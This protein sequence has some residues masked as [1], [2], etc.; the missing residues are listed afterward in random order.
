M[1]RFTQ[2][3]SAARRPVVASATTGLCIALAATGVA[4]AQPAGPS[5]AQRS[6][7]Y[8]TAAS[9]TPTYSA[10]ARR[11]ELRRHNPDG[12]SYVHRKHA[13]VYFHGVATDPDNRSR[14]LKVALWHNGH[15]VAL[16]KTHPTK[17]HRHHF[18]IRTHLYYGKNSFRLLV[19]NIGPGTGKTHL[20]TAHMRLHETWSSH[21]HGAKRVAA[22][23]FK[24]FG[25]GHRQMHALINLWNRESHW[26]THAANGSGAY[27]I[28]QALPGS[29][30]SSA[31]PNWQDNAKTQIRWGLR[32]IAGRYGSPNSAWGHSQATGWY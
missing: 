30:M 24:H 8:A 10:A 25:W 1:S 15:R 12:T 28:P 14:Q 17:H 26:N 31:G 21:Y 20:R 3:I 6:V 19:K 13:K 5:G 27:G 7:S 11:A 18:G 16:V 29:K 9:S 4:V 32:Y 2:P 22:R 23:M